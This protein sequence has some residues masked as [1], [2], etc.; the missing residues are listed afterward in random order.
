M[1]SKC[2]IRQIVAEIKT[3]LGICDSIKNTNITYY[4]FSIIN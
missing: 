1:V 4:D 3:T 2:S